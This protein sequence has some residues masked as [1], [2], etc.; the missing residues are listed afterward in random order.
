M[1]SFLWTLWTALLAATTAIA[2]E[3]VLHGGFE[4]VKPR[5][6]YLHNARSA[7]W[8][9]TGIAEFA[10]NNKGSLSTPYGE[11]FV[12]FQDYLANQILHGSV[13]QE[14]Q[15]PLTGG[16]FVLSYDIRTED[17]YHLRC[18]FTT[19]YGSETVDVYELKPKGQ[20]KQWV[21]RS[22]EFVPPGQSGLMASAVLELELRCPRP[23]E[24]QDYW[25]YLLDN[26]SVTGPV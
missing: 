24:K 16:N 13:W 1:K 15:G 4:E 14:V 17:P 19:F 10:K 18:N 20:G 7:D 22:I 3:Y 2:D 5:S 6:I 25:G 23:A 21:H 11:Q 12:A 26:V 8:T 9:V